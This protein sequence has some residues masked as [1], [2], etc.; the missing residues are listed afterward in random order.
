MFEQELSKTLLLITKNWL[1]SMTKIPE[2]EITTDE[3]AE[4]RKKM[5]KSALK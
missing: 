2:G 1:D 4:T 5:I 3:L